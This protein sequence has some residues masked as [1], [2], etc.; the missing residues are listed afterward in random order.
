MTMKT[1]YERD[2]HKFPDAWAGIEAKPLM[3]LDV[4]DQVRPKNSSLELRWV[5]RGAGESLRYNQ[6]VAAGFVAAKPDELW[7]E[8]AK[9]PIPVSFIKEGKII[10]GD[11]IAMVISKKDYQGALK[12]NA[13]RAI[14][15]GDRMRLKDTVVPQV[16]HDLTSRMPSDLARKI[17]VFVP[18]EQ[19]VEGLS[20]ANENTKKEGQ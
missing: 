15:L 14:E 16:K 7:L 8:R 18:T 17:Q 1:G 3:T 4:F 6:M 12:H 10:Y 20:E 13:L 19:E 9:K 2:E 11:L 5:N